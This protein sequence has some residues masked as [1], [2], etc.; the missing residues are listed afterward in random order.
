MNEGL[1]FGEIN[2]ASCKLAYCTVCMCV[3][4]HSVSSHAEIQITIIVIL[5]TFMLIHMLTDKLFILAAN[6]PNLNS[7]RQYHH[8]HYQRT[9]LKMRTL[10]VG[11]FH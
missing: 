1:I 8:L 6:R 11:A 4:T 5:F 9:N 2:P 3:V 10:S 7:L